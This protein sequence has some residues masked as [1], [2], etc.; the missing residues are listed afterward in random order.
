MTQTHENML[1]SAADIRRLVL[2][3]VVEQFLAVTVGMAD[4]IMIAGVGEMAVSGISLVDV[5][6]ILLINVFSALATG[7]A[8]VSSHLLGQKKPERACR[9][10]NQLIL[11]IVSFS[12][13]LA[14]VSLIFNY[15][16]LAGIYGKLEPQVMD[17]ARTY[18]YLTAMSFPFLA[19]YNGAAALCRSMGNS[20]ISMKVSFL[21]NGMNVVGNA[22]LIFVFHLEVAGAGI[23]TL[24]SRV[25]AALIMIYIIRN[26]KLPLHI[27]KNLRLGFDPDMIRQ[28]LRI[29][30]PVGIEN[31][32]F[33]GGKL[34]VAGLISSF[35]TASIAANAV[36]N[37]LASFQ[38]I[39][40]TAIGLALVTVVGQSVGAKRYEEAKKYAVRFCFMAMGAH[41]LICLPTTLLLPPDHRVLSPVGDDRQ[42]DL[43]DRASARHQLCADLAAVLRASQRAARRGRRKICHVHHHGVHVYLPRGHEL[44]AGSGPGPGSPGRLDCHDYGLGGERGDIQ[45]APLLRRLAKMPYAPCKS[46]LD[47]VEKAIDRICNLIDNEKKISLTVMPVWERKS[48][49]CKRLELKKQLVRKRSLEKTIR[50]YSAP[51][52]PTTCLSWITSGNRAGLIPGL[53]RISRFHWT[54][55]RWCSTMDRRCLRA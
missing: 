9:A 48:I 4:T 49:L 30:L 20:K 33:Q 47:L 27:A 34:L 17:Y 50:L 46:D 31:G 5:L 39:P 43:R 10:A 1:F 22:V 35:G 44:R 51:Y 13:F 24:T 19:A 28:I 38:V 15:Q 36:A 16:I 12:T 8:V 7:G 23:S 18:Y 37:T 53:Y 3:L 32:L 11:V 42:D 45:L 52:L 6:N 25:T 29:G 2:P 41:L 40:G 55:P 54:R 21:M 14:V 26:E